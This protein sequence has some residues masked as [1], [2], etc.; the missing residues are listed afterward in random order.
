MK[1]ML[2]LV[3]V[4]AVLFVSLS[5][6]AAGLDGTYNFSSRTKEGA[7]D[8]PGWAGTMTIKG[9]EIAR[10]YKS[11]DGKQEKFYTSSFKQDGNL[12]VIKHT[13][14]YKPEYVGNEFK[15]KFIQ[16]DKTLTMESED[17]KF[18]ETWTKK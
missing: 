5:A 9:N 12:Y 10:T 17:G 6:F 15:N 18:K 11:P 1:T 14:A 16:N 7:P 13:K 3:A 4:T 8:M 2:K